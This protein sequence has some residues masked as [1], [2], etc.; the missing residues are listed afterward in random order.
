MEYW[1][2]VKPVYDIYAWMNTQ[3]NS[4]ISISK[5]ERS[6][7]KYIVEFNIN[8]KINI[9]KFNSLSA[10]KNYVIEWMQNNPIPLGDDVFDKG[11]CNC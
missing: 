3:T 8:D 6:I 1:K 7:N 2:S 11:I 9:K 10:S 5:N 4:I